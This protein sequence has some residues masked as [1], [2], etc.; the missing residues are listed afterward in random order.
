[1]TPN[2][3]YDL[4]QD[5]FTRAMDPNRNRPQPVGAPQDAQGAAPITP[6][7]AGDVDP[8]ASPYSVGNDQRK[9]DL[10]AGN[11]VDARNALGG[12]AGVGNMLG[13][14]QDGYGG[15]TKAANSVKNTFGRIA[16]RYNNDAT[17][18][19]SLLQD[20]DFQRYFPN[21]KYDGKDRINFG[22]ILSDF[23]SGTP[24]GD[25]DI[26]Q[27]W[28]NGAGQGWQWLDQNFAGD[29]GGGAGG[30]AQ[31]NV[32]PNSDLMSAIL[33]NGGLT[34]NDTLAQIQKELQ[35]LIN[36]QP[37]DLAQESFLGAMR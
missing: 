36:G 24:V 19:Q 37:S 26:S 20:A 34:G 11:G 28:E 21:A 35:A 15:D 6:A 9:Q 18:I 13:F 7:V 16:S 8:G 22:G 1:V 3:P 5:A 17:G 29:A 14:R 32:A 25:V 31:G 2:S 27:G 23:E 4:E 33:A 10:G 30:G 12:Y